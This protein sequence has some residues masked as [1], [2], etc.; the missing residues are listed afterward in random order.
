MI[1]F[2]QKNPDL[3]FAPNK[4]V[5]YLW[6]Q[7]NT[8]GVDS[9]ALAFLTATSITDS[10]IV[11]AINTLVTDL[12]GYGIWTKM[13]AI[14][15]FVGGTAT[16]HKFNL[17]D[18]QDT[19]AA[20]RLVF[21]GGWVHSAT[22]AKPNGTNA[23]ADTF[24]IPNTV[25]PSGGDHLAYYSRTNSAKDIDYVIG[26][27]NTTIIG[28]PTVLGLVAKRNASLGAN[29]RGFYATSNPSLTY[30][31]ALQ[32]N[33]SRD[34]RGLFLGIGSALNTYYILNN[35]ILASNSSL[36]T[37]VSRL[38]ESL[39]IGAFKVNGN[40]GATAY[41]DKECAFASVGSDLSLAEA[42]N[43]YTAVQAFQTTLGRQV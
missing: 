7:V 13:N 9:D 23:W 5:N 21:N 14:W 41:T 30:I 19:N 33:S 43:L 1:R 25:M 31:N 15:P 22:G 37:R 39:P 16:T 6:Q 40:I 12:K 11:N 18:P 10:T 28:S 20:F 27:E 2:K 3:A 35:N 42:A 29:G 26:A 36:Q 8:S 38:V 24:L 17:K 34:T 32:D 4:S